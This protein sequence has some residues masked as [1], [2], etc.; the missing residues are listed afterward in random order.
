MLSNIIYVPVH[1][2]ISREVTE[3]DIDR[4]LSDAAEMMKLCNEPPENH[5]KAYAIAHAQIDDKDPLRF[6][7]TN[8]SMI[9]INPVITRHT[10]VPVDSYEQCTTFTKQARSALKH[11]YHKCEVT[12]Y[13][14]KS[15]NEPVLI[16]NK[17]SLSGIN[18]KIFQHEIEH[19]DGIY[20]YKDP[21]AIYREF[22]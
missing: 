5:Y 8:S 15:L 17:N 20:I 4:V 21:D 13:T 7:V 11:R 12:F 6:F 1:H 2:K 22:V 14:I 16:E 3:Q 9:I 10:Q 18:A 19:M